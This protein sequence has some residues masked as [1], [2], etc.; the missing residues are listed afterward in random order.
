LDVAIFD[1]LIKYYSDIVKAKNRYKGKN[2][3]KREWMKW[4]LEARKMANKKSNRKA[5]WEDIE[6]TFFDF[7]LVLKKLKYDKIFISQFITSQEQSNQ[8]LSETSIICV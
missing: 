8:S 2:V 6:L 3:S 1:P 7:N 5:A 4:I